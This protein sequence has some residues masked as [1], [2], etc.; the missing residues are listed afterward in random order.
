MGIDQSLTS[1]GVFILDNEKDLYY[2]L[3]HSDSSED[4]IKRSE[5]IASRIVD[6]IND[7]N[8]GVYYRYF[9]FRFRSI[10]IC[11]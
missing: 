3:I 10:F 7:Y 9:S 2:G 4:N 1:T 6:L 5:E 8:V 11:R